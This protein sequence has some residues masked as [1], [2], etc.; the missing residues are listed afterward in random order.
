MRA[1]VD[2]VLP[3][4]RGFVTRPLEA[5]TD[6]DAA[7]YVPAAALEA[8]A[9]EAVGPGQLVD[10]ELAQDG[11]QLFGPRARSCRLIPAPALAAE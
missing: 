4:K 3:S 1:T 2:F 8:S 11:K 10:L 9:V 5:A 6:R 7:V